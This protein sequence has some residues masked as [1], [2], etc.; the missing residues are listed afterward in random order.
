MLLIKNRVVGKCEELLKSQVGNKQE[1]LKQEKQSILQQSHVNL[2]S[3]K[4]TMIV[5]IFLLLRLNSA[6]QII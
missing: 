1:E 4:T 2:S 3:L 6:H 5:V